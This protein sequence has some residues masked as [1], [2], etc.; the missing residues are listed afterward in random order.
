[1]ASS[2]A[3]TKARASEGQEVIDFCTSRASEALAI[4]SK[5]RSALVA[6]LEDAPALGVGLARG[7]GSNPLEG[8]GLLKNIN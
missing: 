2:F 7:R 8:T 4:K 6:E 1:M 5:R 3:L